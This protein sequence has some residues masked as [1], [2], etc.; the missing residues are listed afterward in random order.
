MPLGEHIAAPEDDWTH[1]LIIVVEAG[2]HAYPGFP[3]LDHL[4]AV[5]KQRFAVMVPFDNGDFSHLRSQKQ[6]IKLSHEAPKR[7]T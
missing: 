2:T 7:A 6:K 3:T 5:L 1:R 4:A